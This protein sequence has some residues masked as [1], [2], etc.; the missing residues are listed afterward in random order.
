MPEKGENDVQIFGGNAPKGGIA[1]SFVTPGIDAGP[2]RLW[3]VKRDEQAE[4]R[5]TIT[6][7]AA[8]VRPRG[9]PP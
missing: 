9:S 5:G 1:E 3:K 2:N 4:P 6:T 7:D 8:G